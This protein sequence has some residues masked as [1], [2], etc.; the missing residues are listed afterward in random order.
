MIA[1]YE[2][3]GKIMKE[4]KPSCGNCKTPKEYSERFGL[5][6]EIYTKMIMLSF[7]DSTKFEKDK[8][9]DYVWNKK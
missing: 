4:T 7:K 5:W 2:D 9:Y 8:L 3:F 6:S 1:K